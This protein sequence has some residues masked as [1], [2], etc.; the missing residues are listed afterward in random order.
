M[1]DNLQFVKS[2]LAFLDSVNRN[3]V[4][5]DLALKLFGNEVLGFAA[6]FPCTGNQDAER[7][8]EVFDNFYSALER[9]YYP[10]P[11]VQDG[12]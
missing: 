6:G 7:M 1:R 12:S 5:P 10:S 4:F 9:M 3:L 11:G 8:E 2:R